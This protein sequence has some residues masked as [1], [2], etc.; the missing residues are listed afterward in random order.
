MCCIN[1][2]INTLFVSEVRK[3]DLNELAFCSISFEPRRL[4]SIIHHFRAIDIR[5]YMSKMKVTCLDRPEVMT[6]LKNL[7]ASLSGSDAH[8]IFREAQKRYDASQGYT[9]ESELLV[10]NG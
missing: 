10:K 4:R 6:R 2:N 8:V 5:R 9:A 7:S 1:E 3:L